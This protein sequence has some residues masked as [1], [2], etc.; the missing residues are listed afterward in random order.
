M[1]RLIADGEV[2]IHFAPA[3]ADLDAPTIA[4]IVTAGDNITPYLSSLDTP[5]EGEAVPSADLS[6]AFNK[7]VPGTFGGEMIGEFYRDDTADDAYD[8]LPRNT[9]GYVVVRRFGGSTVE[10]TA[11]DVVEVWPVRVIT[12]SPS[13]LSR[14]TVQMFTVNMATLDDP[15]VDAVVTA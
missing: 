3:V 10:L 5:L 7:T 14:G 1:A 6:S 4:E 11:A 15:V 9:L 13:P 2:R 12:R 8:L